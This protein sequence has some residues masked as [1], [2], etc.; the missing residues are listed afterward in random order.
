[1]CNMNLT[2]PITL[3]FS[4]RNRDESMAVTMTLRAPSGVTR[5]AGAN[6]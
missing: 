5:A 2:F 3:S 4:F 6:A 1:M